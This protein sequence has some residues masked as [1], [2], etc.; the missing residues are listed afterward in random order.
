MGKRAAETI[1]FLPPVF[2]VEDGAKRRNF[3]VEPNP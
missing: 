3:L 2:C 1:S